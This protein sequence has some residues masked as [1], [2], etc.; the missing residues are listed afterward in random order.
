[1]PTPS[2]V[3]WIK[4]AD[5]RDLSRHWFHRKINA[6]IQKSNR[7]VLPPKSNARAKNWLYAFQALIIVSSVL[8]IG[9][10]AFVGFFQRMPLLM[11]NSHMRRNR[12][13]VIYSWGQFEPRR[14]SSIRWVC[15][16]F[17]SLIDL[18]LAPRSVFR[19]SLPIAK[20]TR[21]LRA[22]KVLRTLKSLEPQFSVALTMSWWEKRWVG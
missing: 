8:N 10:V 15:T 18:N 16:I 22:G 7:S 5:S 12:A 6:T 21:R 17:A 19:W 20:A 13:S 11:T 1:M 14:S 3:F 4:W 2:K 9:F